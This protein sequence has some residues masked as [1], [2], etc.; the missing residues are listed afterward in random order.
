VAEASA[1]ATIKG[2]AGAQAKADAT[3]AQAE[4]YATYP[5]Q[6]DARRY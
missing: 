3:F 5:L 6:K 4:A 2:G 1:Y